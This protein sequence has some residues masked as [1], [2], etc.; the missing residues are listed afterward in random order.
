MRSR[1]GR[2]HRGPGAG[3]S[4]RCAGRAG[5]G[6]ALQAAQPA[7]AQP[8]RALALQAGRAA[9]QRGDL[10]RAHRGPSLR[11]DAAGEPGAGVSQAERLCRCGAL[12]RDGA[13]P[14]AQP[15]EGAELPRAGAGAEGR[16]GAGARVVHARGQRGHGGADDRG[17]EDEPAAGGGGERRCGAGERPAL[18]GR[19]GRVAAGGR[20]GRSG[21]PLGGDRA[22]RA[23]GAAGRAQPGGGNRTAGRQ[24]AGAHA[25]AGGIARGGGGG[26]DGCFR[27]RADPVDVAVHAGAA[28]LDGG[29]EG[30]LRHRRGGS[31]RAGARRDAH[32]AR[33]AGR[34]LG[35][36]DHEAGAEALPRQGHRQVVRRRRAAHAAG[37][38]GRALRH[39]AG[40]AA[41]HRAGAGR[42]AGLLPRGGALRLRAV[43]PLR[44]RPRAGEER[45]RPAPRAPAREGTA[46]AG[47]AGR[48]AVGG[49]APGRALAHSHGP[50][51]RLAWAAH[52]APAGAHRGGGARA[53][54]G[55]RAGGRRPRLDRRAMNRRERL[56]QE[57]LNAP[58]LMTLGRM[59][60]IP[61]FLYLL[62]YENRR[63]SF[64]AAAVCAISDWLDGW[65]ARVSNKVTTLGKFLD[66][67]ADKV[68]VLSAL[69]MLVRLGRVAVW[70]V[71]VI[72][73]REFLISGLRTIAA[74][75]GLVIS[76]SQG[77]KW[78]T[79]LQLTGI[80]C[81]MLHYHFSIDYLAARVM[82]DFQA[83][84]TTLL[85][86][87]LVPGIASAVDYVRSFYTLDTGEQ[88]G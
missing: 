1:A 62:Y 34:F 71:V 57:L 58:N 64:L 38:R 25:A 86:L 55:A 10:P 4:R 17:A 47:D 82:T 20:E 7:G 15:P 9:P 84:G 51:G 31:A 54:H 79:S 19:G 26:G 52:P 2:G 11:P 35:L 63:N 45:Q 78:K 28:P 32:P 56:R 65:L 72:V 81:L 33:R 27:G 22:C 5:E 85:Y 40:R 30:R 48:A 12:L 83:V 61:V 8:P 87:S 67:L 66:P 41:V 14:R 42:R 29:R 37:Q 18:P 50:A 53:G 21:G 69:V 76:A 36:G 16:P 46:P 80:I 73:A 49:R 70:V 68:I 74:S 59:A 39:L 44:E 88:R 23:G 6:A 13:G 60:L 43:D 77:G 75:E 24:C 3:Q